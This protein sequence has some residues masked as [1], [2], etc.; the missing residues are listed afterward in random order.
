MHDPTE[1]GL[2]TAL[3]ELAEASGNSITFDPQ[4]VPVP[5]LSRRICQ[6]FGLDPLGAIA[7]GALLLTARADSAPAIVRALAEA[8]LPCAEIGAV[9]PGPPSVWI[10]T[11]GEKQI[12]PRPA[13]DEIARMY[14]GS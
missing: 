6:A 3:W 13:R 2:A 12:L 5:P 9:E 11:G 8:G 4:A 14:E 10:Q 1:G 7:S